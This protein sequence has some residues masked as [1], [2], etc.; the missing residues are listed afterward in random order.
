MYRMSGPTG[1]QSAH[2]RPN[3]AHENPPQAD[4]SRLRRHG[5]APAGFT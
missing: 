1:R 4:L 2:A 5:L 3:G